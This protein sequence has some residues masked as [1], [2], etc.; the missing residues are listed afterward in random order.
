VTGLAVCGVGL[1]APGLAGWDAARRVLAGEQPYRYEALPEPKPDALPPNERRRGA[2]T[3][4]WAIAA[5]QEALAG[6]GIAAADAAPVC[7]SSSGDGEIVV[8]IMSALAQPAREVSPTRFHNS[9]HNAA[10]GYWSIACGSRRGA[11]TLCAHDAS[12]GAALL[13]AAAL[14]HAGEGAVL[15]LVYDLP[16]PEPLLSARPIREPL[17]LALALRGE[18][19][20]AALARW[21]VEAAPGPATIAAM[22]IPELASNPAAQALPLLAA[23]ARGETACLGVA[24]GGGG[25]LAVGTRP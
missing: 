12:F 15:L 13:E 19:C 16:Y 3:V 11:V 18:A 10:A 20:A 24:L 14:I 8:Q 6:S 7:A 1:L 21:R 5:A 2:R 23:L 4:R 22:P 9:V 25:S 17:A